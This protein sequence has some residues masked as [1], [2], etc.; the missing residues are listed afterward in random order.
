MDEV[1]TTT[2]Q[3][4]NDAALYYHYGEG[5][6]IDSPLLL[7]PTDPNAPFETVIVEFGTPDFMEL[8]NRLAVQG[9]QGCLGMPQNVTLWESGNIVK[10]RMPPFLVIPGWSENSWPGQTTTP[11]RGR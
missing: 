8:A 11:G 4:I 9:R 1:R 6:W 2:I 10:V 7:P 5:V 3:H